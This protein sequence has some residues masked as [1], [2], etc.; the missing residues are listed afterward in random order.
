MVVTADENRPCQVCLTEHQQNEQ[1]KSRYKFKSGGRYRFK[2]DKRQLNDDKRQNK[3]K[4]KRYLSSESMEGSRSS[5]NVLQL[6]R[7]KSTL[8]TGVTLSN[9]LSQGAAGTIIAKQQGAIIP[10]TSSSDRRISLG[11]LTSKANTSRP[12]ISASQVDSSSRS[13]ALSSEAKPV[14]CLVRKD[15]TAQLYSLDVTKQRK[16]APQEGVNNTQECNDRVMSTKPCSEKQRSG[17]AAV[18]SLSN[19][20]TT[21]A[22]HQAS[23]PRVASPVIRVPPT[24]RVEVLPYVSSVQQKGTSHTKAASPLTQVTP[25]SDTSSGTLPSSDMVRTPAPLL[26]LLQQSTLKPQASSNTIQQI[27]APQKIARIIQSS[28]QGYHVSSVPTTSTTATLQPTLQ[29]LA[30]SNTMQRI[31]APQKIARVIQSG[32]Q[33]HTVSSVPAT[34]TTPTLQPTL[35]LLRTP[36]VQ[37]ARVSGTIK[38]STALLIKGPS[39]PKPVSVTAGASVPSGVPSVPSGVLLRTPSVQP[40]RVSGT[41]KLST[42]LLIKGPSLPKPVSVTAGTSVPFGVPSVPSGVLLRTP[43]VQPARVSGII[44]PSTA[45]LIKGP[46][47]PKPVSVTAEASV[48]FGVPSQHALQPIHQPPVRFASSSGTIQQ[49]STSPITTQPAT[50]TNLAVSTTSTSVTSTIPPQL[51]PQSKVT[52]PLDTFCHHKRNQSTENTQKFLDIVTK[53]VPKAHDVFWKN[54]PDF[55]RKDAFMSIGTYRNENVSVSALGVK[56]VQI[57]QQFHGPFGPMVLKM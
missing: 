38:P 28:Q 5:E 21:L 25:V 24:T 44:Q 36:S 41:I 32:Q 55:R 22:M 19:P 43:S 56:T 13:V 33:G 4:Q 30:S 11:H 42:A 57:S 35:Q 39:L 31:I 6:D 29:P 8:A 20:T 1:H 54:P 16:R 52:R 17:V 48:P 10:G 50:S 37:P 53:L 7:V 45:T 49:A 2:S 34:C 9:A 47:L 46:S 51:Q 40:A 18:T 15:G 14:I 23:K 12:V 27:I 26:K 3:K